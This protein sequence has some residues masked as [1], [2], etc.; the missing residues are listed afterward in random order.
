[1]SPDAGDAVA[2]G[3]EAVQE[4]NPA[5][6]ADACAPLLDALAKSEEALTP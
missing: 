5:G 1:M 4:D 6:V 2:E 3:L